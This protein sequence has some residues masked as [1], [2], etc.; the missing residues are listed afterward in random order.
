MTGAYANLL[1]FGK[2]PPCETLPNYKISVQSAN[3]SEDPV[4]C[5]AETGMKIRNIAITLR[6]AQGDSIPLMI[7]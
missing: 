3:F 6:Q 4:D 5:S 1:L 7:S 2:N